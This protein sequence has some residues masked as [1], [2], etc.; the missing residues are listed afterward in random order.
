MSALLSSSTVKKGR[1]TYFF[2]IKIKC[3]QLKCSSAIPSVGIYLLVCVSVSG[4][5]CGELKRTLGQCVSHPHRYGSTGSRTHH[6]R[7]FVVGTEET[8]IVVI[9]LS[10]GWKPFFSP[11]LRPTFVQVSALFRKMV[12]MLIA[13]GTQHTHS[14]NFSGPL[15]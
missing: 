13:A 2:A 4:R 5:R 12:S 10:F 15:V 3:Y 9:A 14:E 7:K 8:K 11:V 1:S 6:H